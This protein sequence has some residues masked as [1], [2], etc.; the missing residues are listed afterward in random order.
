LEQLVEV[1]VSVEIDL[2]GIDIGCFAVA[3][4]IGSNLDGCPYPVGLSPPAGGALDGGGRD[5]LHLVQSDA[6]APPAGGFPREVSC[7]ADL[8]WKG[9]RISAD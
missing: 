6:L 5:A 9:V 2:E 7:L 8:P 4:Q 3:Q 1:A